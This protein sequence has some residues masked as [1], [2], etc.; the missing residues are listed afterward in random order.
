MAMTVKETLR[1]VG[2]V[3]ILATDL[4]TRVLKI[5]RAGEYEARHIEAVPRALV[6]KYLPRCR[7]DGAACYAVADGIKSMVRFARLNLSQ[8]P[9]P[10]KGPFDVVF[11]RNVM[12]Y[13]DNE[14][15]KRLLAELYRLIRPGGLLMVGHA[16]SLSGMIS[17]FRH[18]EPSV[19]VK[20]RGA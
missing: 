1:G 7:E 3:K 8:P 18:V 14:I 19:F 5:A 12:I 17:S 16:E 13:F 6:S 11:C 9:F 2:D 15:R 20:P 10:M 4:S